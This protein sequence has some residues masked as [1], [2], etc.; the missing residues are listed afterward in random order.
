MELLNSAD[1]PTGTQDPTQRQPVIGL[2]LATWEIW[3]DQQDA[4]NRS[5]SAHL[6]TLCDRTIDLTMSKEAYEKKY[7]EFLALTDQVAAA[8]RSGTTAHPELSSASS[9]V[10]DKLYPPPT[11][12]SSM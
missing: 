4:F 12:P 5:I 9:V 8:R 3:R 7:N 1:K 10:L 6:L 11:D 2:P